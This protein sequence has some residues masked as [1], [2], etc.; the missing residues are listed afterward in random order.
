MAD[1][2]LAFLKELKE[3]SGL[4]EARRMSKRK[5]LALYRLQLSVFHP[6]DP[7]DED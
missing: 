5:D 3:V 2:N 6:I 7:I 4:R 1:K